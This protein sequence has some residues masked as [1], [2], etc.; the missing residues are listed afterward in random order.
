[1]PIARSIGQAILKT[2]APEGYSAV[3]MINILQGSGFT[4]RRQDMLSDIREYTGRVKYETQIRGLHAND[5]VPR[6]WMNE[7][8]MNY[9]Y[10]YKVWA[11]VNYYDPATGQY[12]T[13]V[14]SVYT[15]DLLKK[16]DYRGFIEGVET[17][18][19]YR[20]GMDLTSVDIR[21]LDVNTRIR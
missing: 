7:V 8:E 3:Q 17:A 9:P 16:E 20:E 2:L 6:G 10:K 14:R 11:D 4:Y 1:M 19:N 12:I 13:D 21:G 18:Q 5:V 15:D